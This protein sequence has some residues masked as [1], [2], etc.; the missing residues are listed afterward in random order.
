MSKFYFIFN[1]EA[2]VNNNII[3]LILWVIIINYEKTHLNRSSTPPEG[4]KRQIWHDVFVRPKV[5]VQNSVHSH[6]RKS[7]KDR[8]MMKRPFGECEKLHF[9]ANVIQ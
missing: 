3:V 8:N 2:I 9:H 5:E 7:E 4:L 6:H 1:L